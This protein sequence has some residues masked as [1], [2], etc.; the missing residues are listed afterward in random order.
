MRSCFVG[1]KTAGGH[2]FRIL[3]LCA[4]AAAVL[5][6]DRLPWDFGSR[7]NDAQR[8]LFAPGRA[9]L[10]ANTSRADSDDAI[11]LRSRG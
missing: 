2:G 3:P 10:Q 11:P 7:I 6:S 4:S 5:D 1:D 9:H 8:V